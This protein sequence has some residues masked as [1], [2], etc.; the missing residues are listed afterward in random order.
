MYIYKFHWRNPS[1]QYS[2]HLPYT[3][4]V[5]VKKMSK[6]VIY[7][8]LWLQF[9]FRC[10]KYNIQGYLNTYKVV[11]LIIIRTYSTMDFRLKKWLY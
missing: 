6:M 7:E 2:I 5:H 4:H 10:R 1:L 11:M 3:F 9:Q 8:I